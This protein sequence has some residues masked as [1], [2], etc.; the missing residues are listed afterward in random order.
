[1]QVPNSDPEPISDVFPV[2]LPS[3]PASRL[4]YG[5]ISLLSAY[6]LC[7]FHTHFHF[8]IHCFN[9]PCILLDVAKIVSIFLARLFLFT[10]IFYNLVIS[11]PSRSS[12]H[13]N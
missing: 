5:S 8:L 12:N 9:T 3:W 6:M 11:K 7:L 10:K 1:M 2:D 13:K 4:E